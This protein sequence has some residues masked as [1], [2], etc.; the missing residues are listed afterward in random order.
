MNKLKMYQLARKTF[1]H[2][3]YN[4]YTIQIQSSHVHTFKNKHVKHIVSTT[5]IIYRF[6]VAFLVSFLSFFNQNKKTWVCFQ[7]IVSAVRQQL[8]T[9]SP[10]CWVGSSL[11]LPVAESSLFLCMFPCSVH[12]PNLTLSVEQKW[13]FCSIQAYSLGTDRCHG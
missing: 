8:I 6:I 5:Q 2:R 11:P 7:E 13:C 1:T 4:T 3:H 10:E 12:N 9:N